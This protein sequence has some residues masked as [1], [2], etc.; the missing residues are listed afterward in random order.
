MP[1]DNITRCRVGARRIQPDIAAID[2]G[3]SDRVDYSQVVTVYDKRE[4]GREAR[5]STGEVA[6]T[7]KTPILA[8]PI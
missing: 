7:K 5:Y 2:S 6:E 3:L 8:T 4:D 1:F